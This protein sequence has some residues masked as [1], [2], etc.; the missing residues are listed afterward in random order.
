MELVNAR[1]AL[2]VAGWATIFYLITTV[3]LVSFFAKP[4]PV[5]TPTSRSQDILGP[6]NAPYAIASMGMASGV[7]LYVVFGIIAFITGVMLH[8]LF[9]H[10]DSVRYPIRTF[11][12]LGGRVFG[13]WMRH[14]CSILQ[15]IQVSGRS[16]YNPSFFRD[17]KNGW[18]DSLP[19]SCAARPQ[20]R[21]HLLE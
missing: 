15:A 18:T 14:L 6:F 20:R 3:R 7:V 2:R 10:M 19:F 5:L 13:S 1:R 17:L 8:R 21:S 12:D 4:R 16:Y 11:G 9:L